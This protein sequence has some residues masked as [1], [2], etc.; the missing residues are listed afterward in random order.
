MALEP[1]GLGLGLE[2]LGLE[3]I[4]GLGQLVQPVLRICRILGAQ[5]LLPQCVCI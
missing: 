4:L 1:L 2:Q 3:W 5:W